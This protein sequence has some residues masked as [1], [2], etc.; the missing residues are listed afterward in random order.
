MM[1]TSRT[2]ERLMMEQ[3]GNPDGASGG[4][5]IG[6]LS[7]TSAVAFDCWFLVICTMTRSSSFDWLSALK[8]VFCGQRIT[9]ISAQLSARPCLSGGDL[10][11]RAHHSRTSLIEWAAGIGASL[12]DGANKN[13]KNV[14]P[15]RGG[16][17][18]K[19]AAICSRC[20]LGR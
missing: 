9:T 10:I 6:T 2:Y 5:A 20:R 8:T 15:R 14:L 16:P 13:R 17:R 7:Q 18:W 3:L 1:L 19:R 12:L 4:T 11:G